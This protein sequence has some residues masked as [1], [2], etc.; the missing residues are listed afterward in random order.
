MPVE[1]T[2]SGHVPSVGF[3]CPDA[4]NDPPVSIPVVTLTSMT[5]HASP[6]TLTFDMTDVPPPCTIQPCLPPPEPPP[7]DV[8]P[9]EGH[10][11][12][13]GHPQYF[14]VGSIADDKNITRPS[15][16]A[17]PFEFS[18]DDAGDQYFDSVIAMLPDLPSTMDSVTRVI[19]TPRVCGLNGDA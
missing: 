9:G 17:T 18:F 8:V 5:Q 15:S 1:L 6:A 4:R 19:T 13:R 11:G 16:P 2:N 14:P 12:D 10:D 3:W 7:I